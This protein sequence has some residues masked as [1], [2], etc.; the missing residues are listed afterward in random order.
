MLWPRRG[1]VRRRSGRPGRR[2]RLSADPGGEAQRERAQV[3]H[4]MVAESQTRGIGLRGSDWGKLRRRSLSSTSAGRV[5]EGKERRP[6]WQDKDEG[7]AHANDSSCL[8]SPAKKLRAGRTRSG[9]SGGRLRHAAC[10]PA[11]DGVQLQTDDWQ[12]NSFPLFLHILQSDSMSNLNKCCTSTRDH[13]HLLKA[14]HEKL[15]RFGDFEKGTKPLWNYFDWNKSSG[16]EQAKTPYRNLII[17]LNKSCSSTKDLQLL[18][19]EKYQR[20]NSLRYFE[21][22]IRVQWN[23]MGI[24]VSGF[25][26]QFWLS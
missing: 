13:K 12:T 18:L 17:S 3:M 22:E 4:E 26:M 5:G 15:N 19:R 25:E 20:V 23:W 24:S 16:V 7:E 8:H 11:G 14:H 1:D 21:W 10:L 6:T 9:E 2:Q